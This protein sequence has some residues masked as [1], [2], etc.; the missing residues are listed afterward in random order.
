MSTTFIDFLSDR[1]SFGRTTLKPGRLI[2]LLQL[3]WQVR[4][5]RNRLAA[6]DHD[7]LAEMGI[8]AGDAKREAARGLFDLPKSRLDKL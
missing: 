6:L 2:N 4:R 1:L 7:T 3:V 8:P 5:E